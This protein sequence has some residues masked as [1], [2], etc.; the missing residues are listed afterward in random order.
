[1]AKDKVF[2]VS[3]STQE[4]ID[5]DTF[6]EELIKESGFKISRNEIIRRATLAH[7]KYVKDKKKTKD[8]M[9]VFKGVGL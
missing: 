2:S 7:I 4:V 8:Y 9:E 5:V 6:V 1:M 3:M